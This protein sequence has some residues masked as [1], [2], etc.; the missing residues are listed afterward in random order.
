MSDPTPDAPK[1]EVTTQTT[2]HLLVVDDEP[3]MRR[4]L[5][6][7]LTSLGHRVV[8]AA[9]GGE[10]I[11]VLE[12]DSI[13]LVVSDIVMEPVDGLT[14][15]G[16]MRE[17]YP[18]LPVI[19]IT[20]YGTVESAVEAMKQG[21]DDYVTKPFSTDE[22]SLVISR[23]LERVRL[24]DERAYLREEISRQYDFQGIVGDSEEMRRI[25]EVAASVSTTS[26]G[27]LITGESGTGKEL[28]ARS[29]HFSSQR[30]NN[31]FIVLNCGAMAE[32]VLES[33]LFGHEKGAFTGAHRQ[34]KGRFEL[35]HTGTLFIDEVGELS[36]GSQIRLLR[37]L[38][39]REFERVGGDETI[40]V[41]VRIIAAT[42]KD[43]REE[44]AA[45]RFREDLYY[46]L[47][48]VE[49]PIPPL[50]RRVEDIEPLALYFLKRYSRETGKRIESI[51]PLAREI[52]R[53]YDWPGNV[54]ELENAVERGV[55]L[56]RT[57][58]ITPAELPI[59]IS[60]ERKSV[61]DITAEPKTL[62]EMIEE[63]ERQI[64][65]GTLEQFNGSQTR[66]AEQLGV[67]RTTLRYKLEKYGL[68]STTDEG[69]STIDKSPEGAS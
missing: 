61:L 32:G 57:D 38:Q 28:L 22:L 59:G 47:N 46:R 26:A 65:V 52:M 1:E 42:N 19:M 20:A 40:R 7:A 11:A 29:I 50:R 67:A 17:R 18:A 5:S 15:L 36:P 66:T 12:D 35:A 8:T 55:V 49:I 69:D 10:A 9:T 64:I 54:R 45:G 25:F 51:T 63:I 53:R 48:V 37:V 14:L 21:A 44:V 41:D 68:V 60:G 27:V 30:K 43:L 62:P 34:R 31:P 33:E 39:E 58:T 24:L 2:G 3:G 23:A 4:M 6:R 16:Q 56:A 13:D